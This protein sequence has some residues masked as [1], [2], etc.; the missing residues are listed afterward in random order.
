MEP[1]LKLEHIQKYY[2]NEGNL[3]K[4]IQDIS[5]KIP[6]LTLYAG[7]GFLLLRVSQTLLLP[8]TQYPVRQ[9]AFVA[10]CPSLYTTRRLSF[11]PNGLGKG[12]QS[13]FT[14]FID[15]IRL[16]VYTIS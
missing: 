13:F 8:L 12:L 9:T 16:T 5:V 15:V 6:V 11:L 14:Q 2:G 1:I 3:T 4:A 7:R 10:L